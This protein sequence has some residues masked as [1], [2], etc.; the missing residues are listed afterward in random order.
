MTEPLD[1]GNEKKIIAMVLTQM[2]EHTTASMADEISVAPSTLYNAGSESN[3][4]ARL[5]PERLV[6]MAI[7]LRRW[8]KEY[9]AMAYAIDKAAK[10]AEPIR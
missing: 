8:S 1:I 6:V 10:T 3:P 4:N 9:E 7:V 5:G 2:A